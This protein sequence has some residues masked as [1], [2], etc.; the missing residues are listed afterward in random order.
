V[1]AG[2]LERMVIDSADAV[3]GRDAVLVA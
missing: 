2:G 3:N 1:Q